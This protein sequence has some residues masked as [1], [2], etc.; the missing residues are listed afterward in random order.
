[1]SCRQKRV[2]ENPVSSCADIDLVVSARRMKLDMQIEA[3]L[4][5]KKAVRPKKRKN[6]DEDVCVSFDCSARS[7]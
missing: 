7:C 1:M 5:T 6:A 2:R 4:K 3:I